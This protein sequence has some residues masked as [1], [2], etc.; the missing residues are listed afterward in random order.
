ME[1]L[2]MNPIEK[3]RNE[4]D[5]INN[6]EFNV[7]FFIA[8]TKGAPSGYIT[9]LYET[10]LALKNMGYNVH[11]LHQENEFVGVSSW[12]GDKFDVIPHH[13][14]EKENISISASDFLLIPELFSHVMSKTL[15]VP[16]K[17]VVI[18]QNYNFMTQVI[19]AGATWDDYGIRDCVC[20]TE[21]MSNIVNASFPR[22]TPRVVA[23]SVEIGKE[24]N[25]AKQ[26]IVNIISKNQEDVNKIVKPFFWKYPM[27]KWVAFRDLRGLSKSDFIDALNESAI[28]VWVDRDTEF[29]Y[30][31]IEALKCGNILIGCVP[32]NIPTWM[33]DD[34]GDLNNMGVW[35]FNDE[36]VH[37]LIAGAIESFLTDNMH[38]SIVND[39]SHSKT[40]F[41]KDDFLK[42]VKEVY[43]DDLFNKH[44]LSLNIALNALENNNVEK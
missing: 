2:K 43:V 6:K 39:M 12:M 40:L 13:N 3:L 29:G 7:Y 30:S 38:E 32:N 16:C 5:K 35:Y 31:A 25:D 44:R 42:N 41:T 36:D 27:Y 14:I 21:R 1:D 20:S 26:L 8:D 15:K 18:L 33:T 34:N 28:T 4:I 10:A 11:M 19:P 37:Q 17:R 9:Y 22:V 24:T 23:P